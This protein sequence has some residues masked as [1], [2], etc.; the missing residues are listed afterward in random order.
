MNKK[1]LSAGALW[2]LAMAGQALADTVELSV[3]ANSS[4]GSFVLRIENEQ[5]ASDMGRKGLSLEI[6][7]NKDG[8]EFKRLLL[9]P[10][11]SAL[12]ELVLENGVYGYKARWLSPDGQQV[13]KS[14]SEFS[15]PVFIKVSSAVKRI[16]PPRKDR[17]V[18]I[19][20][21]A[22]PSARTP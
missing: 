8:G 13:D 9:G 2:V 17:I 4:D 21:I 16:I 12:S 20:A 11:C 10:A 14:A 22:G 6:L 3:P 1:L 19:N 7:R 15:S 18:S 5:L